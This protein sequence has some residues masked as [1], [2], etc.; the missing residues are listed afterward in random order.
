MAKQNIVVVRVTADRMA[1][2]AYNLASLSGPWFD[3][4]RNINKVQN[5]P[6]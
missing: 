6:G 2:R 1:T 3:K 4:I 5:S